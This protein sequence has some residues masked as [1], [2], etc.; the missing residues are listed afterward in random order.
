MQQN[1]FNGKSQNY[2]Q[3][4]NRAC[5]RKPLA[6]NRRKIKTN[7]GSR[8][9]ARGVRARPQQSVM[10]FTFVDSRARRGINA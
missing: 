4:K 2:L 8:G 10:R 1:C 9:G 7:P 3:I 5:S 6:M